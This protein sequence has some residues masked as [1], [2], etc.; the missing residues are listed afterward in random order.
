MAGTVTLRG[1][2]ALFVSQTYGSLKDQWGIPWGVVEASESPAAAALRETREEGG[3]V[4]RV[5]GL[6]G[7]QCSSWESAVGLVFLCRHVS[8]EPMPDSQETD[9][10]A[11]F[12]L[13][14]MD[15]ADQPFAPWSARLVRRVLH[16]EHHLIPV[17]SGSPIAGKFACF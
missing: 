14:E 11:Y 8:G 15:E 4:A 9:R 7:L 10:A 13:E 3:I 16:G 12:S 6:I 17:E 5:E 1:D 2:R